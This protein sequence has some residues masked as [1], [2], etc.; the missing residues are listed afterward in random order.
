MTRSKAYLFGGVEIRWQCDEALTEGTDVPAEGAVPLSRRPCRLPRREHRQRARASCRLLRAAPE[1]PERPRRRRMGG[2]LVPGDGFVRSYCNTIPTADG[3]THEAGLRAALLRGLQGPCRADRQ[4]AGRRDHRRRRDDLRRRCC[5]SSSASRNSSA[6]PRTAWQR[7]R[8]DPHRRERHPRS[9]RPLARRLA[10]RGD[11]ASRLG[12]RA[13]RGAPAPPPGKGDQ[14]PERHPQAAAARQARRL[15][16]RRAAQGTEIF[17]VEGDSAPAAPPSRRATARRQAVLPLRGKILNVAGAGRDKL[18]Q[19]QQIVRPRA[20]AR[21][22][23]ARR[24]IARTTCATSEIIIM[25]DADVDGAHIASL[26]M[27][28]FF[29]EM[30]RLIDE[31]APLPR[32]AAA[33]PAH[34]GRQDGLCAR[35]RP[36]RRT[37]E[38]RAF[39]GNGKVEISRFKGLGEMLPPSSRRPRWTPANRT[40]LRVKIVEDARDRRQRRAPDGQQAGGAVPLHPGTRR[41]RHDLDI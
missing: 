33:L 9:L 38:D 35:R 3:G 39:K 2:G 17:I 24:A 13:G 29:Q 32:R 6:R 19:N 25:T 26:L 11:Q 22:R 36:P 23:H 41:I 10:Q 4:Q 12:D 31:R 34:P 20:G 7:A 16:G 37:D 15:L 1:K 28:F 30:P 27:T 40:L 8:G 21:L 5:R 14:P 18:A